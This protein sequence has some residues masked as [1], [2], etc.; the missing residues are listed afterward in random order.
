LD[1]EQLEGIDEEESEEKSL[2]V[3]FPM[4]QISKVPISDD[5]VEQTDEGPAEEEEETLEDE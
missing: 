4:V 1:A 2:D 5:T 3:Y